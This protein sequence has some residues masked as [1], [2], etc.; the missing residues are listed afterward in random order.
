M[1]DIYPATSWGDTKTTLTSLNDCELGISQLFTAETHVWTDT[2]AKVGNW[3]NR[4]ILKEIWAL[5]QWLR[6]SFT[7]LRDTPHRELKEVVNL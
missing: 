5:K 1:A 3:R 2:V 6:V 7:G 4:E